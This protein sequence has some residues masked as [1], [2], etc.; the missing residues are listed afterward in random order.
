MTNG[1]GPDHGWGVVSETP[2]K[3]EKDRETT[4]EGEKKQAAPQSG[5][6]EKSKAEPKPNRPR[7]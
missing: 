6:S 7:A 2:A 5:Q 1:G 3:L 4:R